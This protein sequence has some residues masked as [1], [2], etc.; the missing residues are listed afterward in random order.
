MHI[1][2]EQI[3]RAVIMIEALVNTIII[4][5]IPH[6]SILMVYALI[7][8]PKPVTQIIFQVPRV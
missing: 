4:M 8:A 7:Q 3:L 1:L 6:I 5:D 2:D